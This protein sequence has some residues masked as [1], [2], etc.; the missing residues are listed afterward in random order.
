MQGKCYPHGLDL[1]LVAPLTCAWPA[2]AEAC[3]RH[4]V[5][6]WSKDAAKGTHRGRWLG[7]REE[8]LVCDII[9]TGL[10][11]GAFSGIFCRDVIEKVPRVGGRSL[12]IYQWDGTR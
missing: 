3:P 11:W 4:K 10:V 12:V 5:Q 9:H 7:E 6:Q 8:A 2:D 1:N